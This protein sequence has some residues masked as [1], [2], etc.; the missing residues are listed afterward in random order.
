MCSPHVH[1]DHLSIHSFLDGSIHK[2]DCVSKLNVIVN[3]AVKTKIYD[4]GSE[5]RRGFLSR[6]VFILLN[7]RE[8]LNATP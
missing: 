7:P 3:I 8:Q 1:K 6:P 2:F 4:D 5:A